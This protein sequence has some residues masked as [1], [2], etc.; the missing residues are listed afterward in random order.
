MNLAT[1]EAAD[2]FYWKHASDYP[3][4]DGEQIKNE[5]HQDIMRL[6]AAFAQSVLVK[7]EQVLQDL[8]DCAEAQGFDAVHIRELK[9][10]AIQKTESVG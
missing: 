10:L 1:A 9:K 8:I 3:D 2:K 4:L 7:A 6:A 5:T